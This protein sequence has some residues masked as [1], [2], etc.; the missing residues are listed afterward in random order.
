M[1]RSA[2]NMPRWVHVESEDH[3]AIVTL[4]RGPVNA[5]RQPMYA[6]V[7]EVFDALSADEALRVVILTGAGEKAFQAGN[8]VEEFLTLTPETA[9]HR[10]EV[11]R[12]CF[13]SIYECSVPVIAA[14]NGPAIGTGLALAA[15][16]DFILA[17]ENAFFSLPEI[18]VGII[19]GARH[20]FRIFPQM[21]VRRMFYTAERI[22]A[23]Q[24]YQWGAI[25]AVVPQNDLLPEAIKLAK[26]IARRSP[27]MIRYAKKSL[28]KIE[29]LDLREGYE[30]EQSLTA[31]LSGRLD[32]K[33]AVRA[34]LDKRE[35]NFLGR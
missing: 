30:Y 12:D 3:V 29:W 1:V 18:D 17:S 10:L 11:M 6:E 35:P 15:E 33:E 14:I 31:K 22:T 34:Y 32:P 7:K 25:E 4:Q 16:A 24:A 23:Y 28:N 2:T 26:A 13:K 21:K 19:G 20:A 9:E 5:M 8:D 27:L